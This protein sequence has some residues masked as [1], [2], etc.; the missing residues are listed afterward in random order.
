MM[1]EYVATGTIVYFL[2]IIPGERMGRCAKEL[3]ITALLN[4]TRTTTCK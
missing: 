4:K 2:L 3:L 1:L